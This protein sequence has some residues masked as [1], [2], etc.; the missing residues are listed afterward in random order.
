MDTVLGV[1]VIL[2]ELAEL[3]DS[4]RSLPQDCH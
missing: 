2:I 1:I 3:A 4:Y